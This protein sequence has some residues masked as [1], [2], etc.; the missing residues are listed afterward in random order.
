MAHD[1]GSLVAG[2]PSEFNCAYHINIAY[3]A[4]NHIDR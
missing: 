1:G 3:K 4:C 2:S